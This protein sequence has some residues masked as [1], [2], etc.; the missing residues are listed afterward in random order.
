MGSLKCQFHIHV[1][2]DPADNVSYDA[3]K[4]IDEA[5]RLNYDVIAIT[6]HREIVFDEEW[7][8]YAAEKEVLLLPGIEFE[9]DKKHI[10]C[11]NAHEDINKVNNFKDLKKYKKAHPLSLI[12]APHP[13]FPGKTTLKDNLEKNIELID[14]IE[15]SWA[16]TK[17][18]DFNRKAA[19]VAEKHK[20]PL[21]ATA[22][23]HLL[24]QLQTGGHCLI[25]A[26]PEIS[27]IIQAI[28]Q[29]KIKSVHTPTTIPKIIKYFIQNG[30][31]YLKEITRK[32]C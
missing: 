21:I 20:K 6:C 8:K 13:F 4:L 30:W 29:N 5:A 17:K 28:N 15:I 9:I 31:Q 16:Y 10:L 26:N 32:L 1:K 22:D 12:I 25:E 2:G 3:K 24:G 23:C 7:R 11:I 14:A 27:S 18:I 19:E